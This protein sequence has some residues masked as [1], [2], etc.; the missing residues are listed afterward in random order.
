MRLVTSSMV[1]DSVPFRSK[2]LKIFLKRFGSFLASCKI[3][4]LTSEWSILT[5]YLVISLSSFSGTYQVDSI[6]LQKYSSL[7]VLIERSL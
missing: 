6:I 5:V 7:G 4:D 1:K 3:L 2:S